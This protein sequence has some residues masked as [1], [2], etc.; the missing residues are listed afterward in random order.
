MGQKWLAGAILSSIG[1]TIVQKSTAHDHNANN[2]EAK[3]KQ[4][5]VLAE[6]SHRRDH[7]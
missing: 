1:Y 2:D 5:V 4:E 6:A 3:D 7:F